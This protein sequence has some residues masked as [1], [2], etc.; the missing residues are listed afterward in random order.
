MKRLLIILLWAFPV[1]AQN[2][3]PIIIMPAEGPWTAQTLVGERLNAP[4]TFGVGIPD[5]WNIDC[6]G[7]QLHPE[8]EQAPTKLILKYAGTQVTSQFRCMAHWPSGNAEWVQVDSQL[9]CFSEVGNGS[10]A[11]TS[12]LAGNLNYDLN[13][14]ISTVSSGGGNVLCSPTCT[15]S[16]TPMAVDSNPGSPNTG[17]ITVTTGA[18]TFVIQKANFDGYHDAAIGALHEIA[19]NNHGPYD[20]FTLYGPSDSL[21]PPTASS[22]TIAG[23]SCGPG[24]VPTNYTGAACTTPYSSQNDSASTAI[25]EENGPLRA[26]ITANFDFKNS[27]GHAY[28]HGRVR[29]FFWRNR[30]DS[31]TEII[32]ENAYV[33]VVT[34]VTGVGCYP[35]GIASSSCSPTDQWNVAYKEFNQEEMRETDNL[36][37][38]TRDFQFADDA[39]GTTVSA[40][41]G[42]MSSAQSA[43]LFQGYSNDGEWFDWPG[44]T[45]CG[46]GVTGASSVGNSCVVSYISR[47]G[48]SNNWQYA[49]LGYQDTGPTGAG[50]KQ[51]AS[52]VYPVGWSD[53]DDGA[54]G[55]ETGVYQLA[56][57]WPK[58]LEYQPGNTSAGCG[59]VS[60]FCG[61]NNEIRIGIWPN[62]QL[63]NTSGTPYVT[64]PSYVTTQASGPCK[65]SFPCQAQISYVIGWPQTQIHDI[66]WN[67]HTGTQSAATAQANFLYFQ[68]RLLAKPQS[69]TYWNSVVDA[70]YSIPALWYP[71]PDPVTED[72]FY[73]GAGSTVCPNAIGSC[74]GDVGGTGFAYTGSTNKMTIWRYF[75][76]I[77]GGGSQGNQFEQRNSFDL[78]WLQRGC[79]VS[80]S[81]CGAASTLG[82]L[83]GRFIWVDHFDRMQT[84]KTL[85]RSNTVNKSGPNAGFRSMCTSDPECNSAG[86]QFFLYG[87]PRSASLPSNWNGGMQNFGDDDDGGDHNVMWGQYLHYFLTGDETIRE[88]LMEGFKD[89]LQ[90]PFVSWFNVQANAPGN[91]SPGHGHVGAIRAEGHMYSTA[92]RAMDFE[93]SISDPDA[94]TLATITGGNFTSPGQVANNACTSV[95]YGSTSNTCATVLEGL[96]QDLAVYQVLPLVNAGYPTG[97]TDWLTTKADCL[98]NTP[99]TNGCS[100]GQSPTRGFPITLASGENCNYAAWKASTVSTPSNYSVSPYNIAAIVDSN[101]N[102]ELVQTA[103]TAGMGTHPTWCTTPINCTTNDNTVV[104]QM[105]G[106]TI[107]PCNTASGGVGG[108]VGF[109]HL[110][111]FMNGVH[112]NGI[113]DVWTEMRKIMGL[114]WHLIVGQLSGMPL[115]SASY[116]TG[117]GVPGNQGY[118]WDGCT[119]L[120]N[121]T[122]SEKGLLDNIYGDWLQM[123]QE[124]CVNTNPLGVYTARAGCNYDQSLDYINSAPGCFGGQ[125]CLRVYPTGA[126]ACV[127]G[128]GGATMFPAIGGAGLVTN[129][130]TD[131]TGD[132][133]NNYQFPFESQAANNGIIGQELGSHEMKMIEQFI[134]ANNSTRTAGYVIKA[135]LP[136]LLAVP[137]GLTLTSGTNCT[138]HTTYIVI[139][140]TTT[141]TCTITW[142]TPPGLSSVN[143]VSYRLK[144]YP[145][146]TGALTIYGNGSECP[147]AGKTLVPTL[148]F[149]SDCVVSSGCNSQLA[150]GGTQP[151]TTVNSLNSYVPTPANIGSFVL[152]PASNANWNNGMDLPD[153]GN[154]TPT[155]GSG[156]YPAWVPIQAAPFVPGCNSAVPSGTSYTFVGQPN[157]TYTFANYAFQNSAASL[158]PAS[159]AFFSAAV[160]TSSGDS[161]RSL[162]LTAGP[163]NLTSLVISTTGDFSQTN[164]CSGTLTAGANCTISVTFTA[165]ATG[166]RTGTVVATYTGG[167]LSSTLSGFGLAAGGV[168]I[169]PPNPCVLSLPATANGTC[170]FQS[171]TVGLPSSDSP[172]PETLSNTSGA[173]LTSIACSTTGANS[174]DFTLSGTCATTLLNNSTYSIP[175]TFTPGGIGSRTANLK[176]SYGG[177]GG[178]TIGPLAD[179]NEPTLATALT[180]VSAD[181]T[182]VLV[183]SGTCTWTSPLIYNPTFTTYVIFGNGGTTTLNDAV[184]HSSGSMFQIQIPVGKTF[185]LSGATIQPLSTNPA[186]Y[187]DD[188]V[189]VLGTC[190]SSG[191]P[192]FRLDHM[193]FTGSTGSTWNSGSGWQMDV[194]DVFGVA[195]HN[196]VTYPSGGGIFGNVSHASYLGV[197]QYGDNSWTQPD[198]LG[199]GNAFYFEDNTITA[200]GSAP[201]PALIVDCD[202]SAFGAQHVGACRMALR[203]NTLISAGGTVHGTESGGR[204]RGGRQIEIYDNQFTC[205]TTA[206]CSN[207]FQARSGVVYQFGNTY[208]TGAGSFFNGFLQLAEFRRWA[209][210]GGWDTCNGAGPWDNND[211]VVYAS[212]TITATSGS[213]GA[214]TLV[215]TDTSQSWTTNQWAPGNGSSY[216][217]VNLTLGN[218]YGWEISSST[219]NS[220]SSTLYSQDSYNSWPTFNVGDHYQILKASVCIDQPSRSL[221][222]LLSGATPPTGWVNEVLDPSYEWNDT[223]SPGSIINFGLMGSQTLSLIANRDWYQ[224]SATSQTANTSPTSP[225]NGTSGTGWGIGANRPTSCSLSVS[226]FSTN[227]GSQGT[228]Y[229]CQSGSWVSIY[230][231]YTY[232]H[233]LT[234][235][236]GGS[237]SAPLAGT[238]LG[239]TV[240]LAPST[241]AFNSTVAG[242]GNS[243]DSPQTFI[244]T[245]G[246]AGTVT[247]GTVS[248]S[249]AVDFNIQ[250]N[251]CTAP[252]T[253]GNTCLVTANFAPAITDIGTLT[254]TLSIAFTGASGS[255][256]TAALS[257]V[258]TSPTTVFPNNPI[259]PLGIAVR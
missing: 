174:L 207:G 13:L 155:T 90:N 45:L 144:Y 111:G 2:T 206:G 225:F 131:I 18:A 158:T 232:P 179:C 146:Q 78:Q 215:V 192:N 186:N 64:N 92:A 6:P 67:F 87:D 10:C 58:S 211:G 168:I 14:T 197:G 173:G 189:S 219:S 48:S 255:P 36:S 32:N 194:A 25:I 123:A 227:V 140:P 245:N 127:V 88:Q 28:F 119:T 117:C 122:V 37:G 250:S 162:T 165:T 60:P 86:L 105:I 121:A 81:V 133:H 169:I 62:Q 9:P 44:G 233:P 242:S 199:T 221:S 234:T 253:A 61:N 77:A 187:L 80:G 103:G 53:F 159:Q 201:Q 97:F 214:H 157:T 21:I 244:F 177:G 148:G 19:G 228:L 120:N 130:I 95:A 31:K 154:G 213:G 184:I 42:T 33:P 110:S 203:H 237:V 49:L 257:G 89:R 217:I 223:L 258:S 74:L 98:T 212:G 136:Q 38:A 35:N 170:T 172:E 27:S 236:S 222:T 251:G 128:C 7:T 166:T 149:R 55:I 41:T 65:G 63:W 238:G 156:A 161:P 20:G 46:S 114:N 138:A 198:S 29:M 163:S 5:A 226:Y 104:W 218:T 70:T 135:S 79:A 139:G 112:V 96:L 51:G 195:D 16:F 125:N 178:P 54:N 101:N 247:P 152:S 188:M 39:T 153:C 190:N 23:V 191:C 142:A 106:P 240:T 202:H 52:T 224:E 151:A 239:A 102:L 115:T 150:I 193:V 143:G 43:Y 231:P 85:P 141:G 94:D 180:S 4:V 246:T 235:S 69:S 129:G 24:P 100:Q 252:V 134:L 75:G 8:N 145:C 241:Y 175:T 113:Y 82:S 229:Q 34:G 167:S 3:I 66:Y 124:S 93:N 40:T 91:T 1:F 171:Q 259:T 230:T 57:Y 15:T 176:V 50:I 209:N 71:M 56:M 254:S 22:P 160:G 216:S 118:L 11:A 182:T 196:T 108:G 132:S 30:T 137:G 185:R 147:T 76:W 205:N 73:K 116:N 109:R 17:T 99:P 68:H 183:P 107:P 84:E 72:T 200:G 220:V 249:N 126:S 47:S 210:L 208:T 83:A 248:L 164:T 12:S 59:G 26:A 243:S 204:S 181:N 256:V